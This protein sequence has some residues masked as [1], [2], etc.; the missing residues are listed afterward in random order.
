MYSDDRVNLLCWV[1]RFAIFLADFKL[2][3]YGESS[4]YTNR[5]KKITP[6][7]LLHM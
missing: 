7:N 3:F 4:Y 1:K 2:I 5:A 6:P